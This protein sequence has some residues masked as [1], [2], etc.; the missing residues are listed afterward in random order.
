MKKYGVVLIIAFLM[1]LAFANLLTI[2]GIRPD[3]LVIFVLY[4][5]IHFGSYKGV[6]AGF[7]IGIIVSLFD[8]GINIGALSLVYSIVGYV[9]DF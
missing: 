5:A 9:G 7:I 1:Q 3:F 2:R 8:S 4:F 6:L